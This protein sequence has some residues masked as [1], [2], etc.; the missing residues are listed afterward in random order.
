MEYKKKI[1]ML[2]SFSVGK[3]SLV[4]RY[5]QSIFDDKY[6]TTVGVKV[7][8][9]QI[10]VGAHTVIMMLW[11]IYGEDDF[12]KLRMSYLRGANGY[13]LVAD[14]TRR[15]TFEKALEIHA[16]VQSGPDAAPAVLVVNKVD[17]AADWEVTPEMLEDLRTRG[18]RHLE[19]S[20]KTGQGVELAFQA[21]ATMMLEPKP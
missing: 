14:G 16:R 2:G 19:S 9:K 20:A 11:D 7:D 8:K 13:L 3:T 5:V 18:W 15:A 21:L 4:R 10:Q 1:C 17:L 12:Q 6:L